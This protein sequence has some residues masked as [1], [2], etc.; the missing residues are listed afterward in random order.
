MATSQQFNSENGG[1]AMRTQSAIS[2][3]KLMP[4]GVT[5]HLQQIKSLPTF[6]IITERSH[7]SQILFY[8]DLLTRSLQCCLCFCYFDCRS[9]HDVGWTCRNLLFMKK[10]RKNK[11]HMKSFMRNHHLCFCYFG[12]RQRHDVGWTCRN[13][14][15]ISCLLFSP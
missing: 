7:F 11:L 10:N 8:F 4:D 2:L 6:N 13:L 1:A 14:L 3:L 9:K 15:F 5:R 12:Y